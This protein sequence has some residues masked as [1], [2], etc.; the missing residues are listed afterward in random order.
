MQPEDLARTIDHTLLRAD[1]T[2]TDVER[3]C[4]EAASFRF[5]AVCVFPHFVPLASACLQGTDVKVCTVIA[6]PFG[7]ETARVK[8]LAAGEAV[9]R[10]AA[11]V[12][13]VIDV[14]AF[15]SG[16]HDLV[17]DELA[18]VVRA[19]RTHDR[20]VV[21]AIIETCYLDDEQK[22]LACRICEEAA[23]D[24]VKTSTGYGPAGATV[25]DVGLLRGCLDER[26]GVK[27]S[28]GIRTLH[29]A[30]AM[31]AA[32]ASRIGTSAGAAIMAESAA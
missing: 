20:T 13:V 17:R 4:R 3:L 11:E 12:D 23:V 15:L 14:P 22:L 2:S 10:G 1:G 31:I 29:D 5:A 32:G 7:A 30:E 19:V 21:K 18:G 28:G 6:F 9:A 25:H 24:F 8:A 27:A 16:D 26:V